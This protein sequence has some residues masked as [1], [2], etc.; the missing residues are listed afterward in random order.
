MTHDHDH[1]RLLTLCRCVVC[2]DGSHLHALT[3][4]LDAPMK[5]RACAAALVWLYLLLS[6]APMVCAFAPLDSR[7]LRCPHLTTSST[8]AVRHARRN[9]R[10]ICSTL[11]SRDGVPSD[12]SDGDG[13]GSAAASATASTTAVALAPPP[14]PAAAAAAAAATTA[15]PTPAPPSAAV[16][17]VQAA[18]LGLGVGGGV[19]AFKLSVAWLDSFMHHGFLAGLFAEISSLDFGAPGGGGG[20]GGGLLAPDSPLAPLATG[21]AYAAVPAV[22]GVAVA[23]LRAAAGGTLGPSGAGEFLEVVRAPLERRPD[24]GGYKHGASSS[25]RRAGGVP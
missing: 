22:G 25:W 23:A 9:R 21:L 8:T 1:A 14:P 17:L 5:S 15:T 19:S 11:T 20:G 16:F 4:H 24:G 10:R 7:L 18:V 6:S 12:A 3:H 13:D 2:S